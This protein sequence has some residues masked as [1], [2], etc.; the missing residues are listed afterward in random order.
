MKSTVKTNSA[1]A[2]ASS[3]I[4]FSDKFR[5]I[6]THVSGAFVH[7]I[8]KDA[9]E[10]LVPWVPSAEMGLTLA[11]SAAAA[12]IAWKFLRWRNPDDHVL[13]VFHEGEILVE[14][15]S[16]WAFS[17]ETALARVKIEGPQSKFDIPPLWVESRGRRGIALLA[18]ANRAAYPISLTCPDIS[19]L[20][21]LPS[22]V[23]TVELV[24]PHLLLGQLRCS[25]KLTVVGSCPPAWEPL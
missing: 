17:K 9:L 7:D 16:H 1:I 10:R 5:E 11:A 3:T 12:S 21:V 24:C 23:Y 18:C 15:R 2:M 8:A 6:S 13:H 25:W 20:N 22:G 14:P 19:S 4:L